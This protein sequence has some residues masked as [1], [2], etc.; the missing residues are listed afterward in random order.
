[1]AFYDEYFK[2][3]YANLNNVDSSELDKAVDLFKETSAAG[4]KVIC[5]GNGGSAAMA[6][7]V[8]VDL[9]KNAGIRSINFN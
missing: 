1:M 3:V 2:T 4:G 5:C 6:S 7:H 8:A 9:T